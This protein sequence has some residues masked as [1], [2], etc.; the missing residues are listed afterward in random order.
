MKLYI[1]Q[2]TVALLFS[3]VLSS[4]T[5][6][7][8]TAYSLKVQ[9]KD[10]KT[11]L[12]ANFKRKPVRVIEPALISMHIADRI[13]LTPPSFVLSAPVLAYAQAPHSD[14]CIDFEPLESLHDD[15]TSY[16][17]RFLGTRYRA[18]GRSKKGFDCSNFTSYIMEH[19]GYKIPPGSSQ[20]T[21]GERVEFEKVRKGDLLF[22]GYK[23]KK[24]GSYRVSHVA[25]VT[26]DEGEDIHFIHAAR[27]GIII[28]NLQSS[29]WK[30]YYKS[31]FLF[32]KR[33]ILADKNEN[34]AI[35]NNEFVAKD[36]SKLK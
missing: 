4:C 16:A 30:S 1:K 27:R 8:K 33:I 26:S 10:K 17:K 12:F 34:L 28:D 13:F 29:A 31:R 32:A 14:Q 3:V 22:F 35:E 24:G 25:M 7:N 20:A 36:R 2:L 19:F 23:S 9:S 5:F 15:I 11:K 6:I 21:H 18:G